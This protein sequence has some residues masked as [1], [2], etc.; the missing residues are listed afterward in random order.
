LGPNP[1]SAKCIES[2]YGSNNNF[3]TYE[4]L[5]KNYYWRILRVMVRQEATRKLGFT[6]TPEEEQLRF[7][8]FMKR[9]L[10]QN[11]FVIYNTVVYFSL[12]L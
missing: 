12:L 8:F 5:F 2:V 1:D 11:T 9:S 3:S 10:C 4:L 7:S 6:I